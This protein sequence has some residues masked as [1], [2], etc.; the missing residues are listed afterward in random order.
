MNIKRQEKL[1]RLAR[2]RIDQLVG[3][4]LNKQIPFQCQAFFISLF[5]QTE[6][7]IVPG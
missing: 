3:R 7:I 1:I 2:L 4:F 5:Y 6:A